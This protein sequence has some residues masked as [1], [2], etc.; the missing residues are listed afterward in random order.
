MPMLRR[1]F[2]FEVCQIIFVHREDEIELVEIFKLDLT[3]LLARQI[4]A[5]FQCEFLRAQVWLLTDMIGMGSS[6]I[7][8]A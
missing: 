6:R 1:T 3:R 7:D 8:M 4:K 5:A 2:G